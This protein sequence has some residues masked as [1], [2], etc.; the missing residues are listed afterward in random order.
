MYLFNIMGYNASLM[1]PELGS[2]LGD[3]VSYM[4]QYG[5]WPLASVGFFGGIAGLG[6]FIDKLSGRNGERVDAFGLSM[7][8]LTAIGVASVVAMMGDCTGESIIY[9]IEA[10]ANVLGIMTA[11][12]DG[13][14]SR[15]NAYAIGVGIGLAAGLAGAGFDYSNATNGMDLGPKEITGMIGQGWDGW[16]MDQVD[17]VSGDF[18]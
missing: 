3:A 16:W 11:F 7:A 9:A 5:D 6:V 4:Q 1:N 14:G 8:A 17:I 2:R 13:G 18:K 15:G 10:G 12:A